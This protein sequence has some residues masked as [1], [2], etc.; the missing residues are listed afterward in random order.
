VG[1]GVL[2]EGIVVV[3]V[4]VLVVVVGASERRCAHF[5]VDDDDD[6][7]VVGVEEDVIV[8]VDAAGADAEGAYAMAT[9]V[10]VVEMTMAVRLQRQLWSH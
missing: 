3:V 5:A 2:G 1:G 4:V 6:V 10:E 7:V 9:K 8:L